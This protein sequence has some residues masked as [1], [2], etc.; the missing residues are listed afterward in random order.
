MVYF[1]EDRT[2]S[3]SYKKS[4]YKL[5]VTDIT[6]GGFRVSLEGVEMIFNAGSE[7]RLPVE[8]LDKML[9]TL[10]KIFS[11]ETKNIEKI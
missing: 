4:T 3:K 6:F 7:P 9:C 1:Y 11:T 8:S 2:I 10:Q 5:S